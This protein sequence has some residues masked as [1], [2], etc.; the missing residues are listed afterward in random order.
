MVPKT[1]EQDTSYNNLVPVTDTY[2]GSSRFDEP[3][4][5]EL[6]SVAHTLPQLLIH[7]FLVKAHL[8]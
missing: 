7:V 3:V 6:R 2:H 1:K 8:V 5:S 4:E